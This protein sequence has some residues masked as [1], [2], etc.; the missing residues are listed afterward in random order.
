M[1]HITEF[2]RELSGLTREKIG[3]WASA[4]PEVTISQFIG[5]ILVTWSYLTVEDIKN[6]VFCYS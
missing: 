2:H 3:T 4:I 6:K 1:L 5:H